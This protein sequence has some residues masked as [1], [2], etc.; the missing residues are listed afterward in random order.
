MILAKYTIF[1]FLT[2]TAA[3]QAIADDHGLCLGACEMNGDLK[4]CSFSMKVNLH[5]GELGYYT[6]EECGDKINPTIGIEK[7]TTYI[8]SQEVRQ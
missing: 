7:N 1:L 6:V 8:F 4:V 5:A 3:K 2:L